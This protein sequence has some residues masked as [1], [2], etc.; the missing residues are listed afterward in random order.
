MCFYWDLIGILLGSYWREFLNPGRWALGRI[1]EAN[2]DLKCPII[3]WK[4]SHFPTKLSP[5]PLEKNFL[6]R[7]TFYWSTIVRGILG[8]ETSSELDFSTH[9]GFSKRANVTRSSKLT[10]VPI[11][12]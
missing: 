7:H 11:S 8:Y 6:I 10:S 3:C 2:L 12:P 5:L 1:D 9:N 4:L